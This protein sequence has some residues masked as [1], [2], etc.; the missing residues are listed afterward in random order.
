MLVLPKRFPPVIKW[1]GSKRSVANNLSKYIPKSKRYFEPFLGGGA[2]LPF[3]KIQTGFASDIIPEL[4]ALWNSIKT[5]PEKVSVEYKKRWEKLQKEGYEVFYSIRDN[6][7]STRNEH[8]FLFLT[9]TCV[10]GLIRYN[11]QGDFNNSFHLTRPGINPKNLHDIIFQWHLI[12]KDIE[13]YNCDYRELTSIAKEDDF[14]F[15]DPP[16]GGTKGRYTKEEF[17]LDTFFDE[18]ARL[19]DRGIKWILTFDGKAGNR[20]YTYELPSN[21]YFHKIFIQTGHSPFTKLMNTSID[22]VN[23]S[24]YLNY[25]PP[26]EIFTEFANNINKE[27]TLFSAINMQ[28]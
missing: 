27:A 4:I 1:S 3:R 7:N 15:F 2:L 28:Y 26:A 19:N 23:E 20:N 9:R 24:V 13:F 17:D 5:D 21:L 16:Y 14:I 6:F 22:D 11:N 18:L 10:N 25:N 12:I 8:D